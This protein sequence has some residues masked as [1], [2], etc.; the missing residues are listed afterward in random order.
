MLCVCVLGGSGQAVI[1]PVIC[2]P[3]L[4]C[5]LDAGQLVTHMGNLRHDYSQF[6]VLVL[7]K[8]ST[9]SDVCVASLLGYWFN[10]CFL[11]LDGI[12]IILTTIQLMYTMS[13]KKRCRFIFDYNSRIF[14]SIFCFTCG[15]RNEHSTISCNVL[16]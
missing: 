14:W 9:T 16:T 2:P 12:Y 10:W 3:G 7:Y 4:E 6:T 1:S 15:N 13:R 8:I 11:N 5:L